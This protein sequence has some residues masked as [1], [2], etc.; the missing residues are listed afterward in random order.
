MALSTDTALP[1]SEPLFSGVFG[2]CS[3]SSEPNA[4]GTLEVGVPLDFN[5]FLG[6]PF[7]KFG[8]NPFFLI[9]PR[10]VLPA[11][12]LTPNPVDG[13]ALALVSGVPLGAGLFLPRRAA[14]ESL[15]LVESVRGVPFPDA[16]SLFLR[17]FGG[18]KPFINQYF[19]TSNFSVPGGHAVTVQTTPGIL[20]IRG[21]ALVSS[22]SSVS[23]LCASP[24][25]RSSAIDGESGLGESADESS[26]VP[27]MI[28]EGSYSK[29]SS[30]GKASKTEYDVGVVFCRLLVRVGV[31]AVSVE[32]MLE[33]RTIKF[34]IV[35]LGFWE[36]E[37]E[38]RYRTI[39]GIESSN[40]KN[41]YDV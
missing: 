15:F 37:K 9:K 19:S 14:S 2:S 10:G 7:L 1:F 30:G 23:L 4:D 22:S 18:S 6:C 33:Y 11:A 40:G 36:C 5:L 31:E 8:L 32:T 17:R 24:A 41:K 13:D 29:A 34:D 20:Y 3:S 35:G 27:G 38:A 21:T 39:C 25:A 26:S 28:A 16:P 12:V